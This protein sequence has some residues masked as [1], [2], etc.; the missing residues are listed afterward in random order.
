MCKSINEFFSTWNIIYHTL[1][2]KNTTG[3]RLF[4][5]TVRWVYVVLEFQFIQSTPCYNWPAYF[6][7]IALS[8]QFRV[9]TLIF[10]AGVVPEGR[11]GDY[12]PP[13]GNLSPPSGEIKQF[14]GERHTW[15]NFKY[16]CL[17]SQ[18]GKRKNELSALNVNNKSGEEFLRENRGE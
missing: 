1:R 17:F 9:C 11:Q 14:V 18:T 4:T 5:P 7:V 13:S 8:V 16:S 2:E 10:S 12:R 15:G 3:L 6:S